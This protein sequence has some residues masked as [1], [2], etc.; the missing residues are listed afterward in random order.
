MP[1]TEM[2]IK[3]NLSSFNTEYDRL[4][5]EYLCEA[6]IDII[7]HKDDKNYDVISSIYENIYKPFLKDMLEHQNDLIN[8]ISDL[9]KYGTRDG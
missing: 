1:Y 4:T 7:N 2:F 3:D 9:M 6:I 8:T 5:F